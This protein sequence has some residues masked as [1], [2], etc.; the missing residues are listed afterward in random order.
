VNEKKRAYMAAWRVK[1]AA[2]KKAYAAAYYRANRE[3]QIEAAKAYAR[4]HPA[5]TRAKR[6]TYLATNC[7]RLRQRY[8]DWYQRNRGASLAKCA[9]YRLRNRERILARN[10]NRAAM[11]RNAGGIHTEADIRRMWGEQRG[12]CKACGA[13]LD[14]V[15]VHVDHITPLARGG[16]NGADNLQLLCPPCNLSKGAKDP[17]EWMRLSRA[18]P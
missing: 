10:R 14:V 3:K 11:R 5:K 1:N 12:K 8:A 16:H 17:S 7:A 15:G 6:A 4:A 9:A 2:H 18:C 13:R